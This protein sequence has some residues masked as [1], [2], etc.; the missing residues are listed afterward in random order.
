MTLGNLDLVVTEKSLGKLDT[1]IAELEKFVDARLEEYKPE[2]YAGDADAAKKDR[3]EL[4]KASKR[5]AD[6]RRALIAECMKPYLSFEERC[7]KMEQKIAEASG[8]LDEIVKSKEQ[9]QKNRKH[10]LIQYLWQNENFTLFPLEKIF[11]PKWLNKTYKESDIVED[12]KAIID[13][14]YRDLKTIEKYTDDADTLKAHYLMSLDI[15][16]TMQYGD[17]LQRQ[18]EIAQKEA[19]ERAEREH[20]T[21]LFTQKK[22]LE[23]EAAGIE[24]REEASSLASLALGGDPEPAL[25]EFVITVKCSDSDLLALK[26]EINKMGIIFSVEELVF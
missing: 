17:E 18:R 19:E 12:I 23:K 1:N 20:Q 21:A 15:A 9:E 13:R 14:T 6:T 4:N 7:K 11:N 16:E 8:A 5:I 10:S 2:L 3:A 26:S 22:E 24:R 25:K